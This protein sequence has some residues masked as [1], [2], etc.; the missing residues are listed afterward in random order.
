MPA[1]A[2]GFSALLT[3]VGLLF[4]LGRWGTWQ[5]TQRET[6]IRAYAWPPGSME[7]FADK[8]PGRSAAD[9]A[10][11]EQALRQFFLVH[12]RSDCGYV[13]MPSRVVDDLWHEFILY[14]RE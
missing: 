11:V 4:V 1:A 14:T 10:Q 12:L 8:H 2:T 13:S 7:R 5:R 6:F 3:G 9:R